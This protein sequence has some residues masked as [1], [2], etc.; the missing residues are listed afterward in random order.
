MKQ[1]DAKE[2]PE[3]PVM[4]TLSDKGWSPYLAGALADLVLGE[5][6]WDAV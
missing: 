1:N 6:R 3:D 5:G 2:F 4:N